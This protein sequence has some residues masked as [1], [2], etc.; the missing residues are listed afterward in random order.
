MKLI[1][2][3]IK[4]LE[5]SDRYIIRDKNSENGENENISSYQQQK[6]EIDKMRNNKRSRKSVFSTVSFPSE[7]IQTRINLIL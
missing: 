4:L 5:T 2:T 1:D 6:N 7:I 3:E